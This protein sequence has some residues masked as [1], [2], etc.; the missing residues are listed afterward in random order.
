MNATLEDLNKEYWLRQRNA[1]NILWTTKEG[2]NIPINE[3]TDEHLT[4]TIKMLRREKD[5]KYLS[6]LE[7]YY[8]GDQD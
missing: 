2:K 1:G 4:N 8:Y 3:M 6:F 7:E 5:S